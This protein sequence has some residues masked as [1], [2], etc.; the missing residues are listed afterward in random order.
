LSLI[1]S[2]LYRIRTRWKGYLLLAVIG[3]ALGLIAA[4]VVKPAVTAEYQVSGSVPLTDSLHRFGLETTQYAS[5]VVAAKI[6]GGLESLTGASDASIKTESDAV[7]GTTVIT[8]T[9][10]KSLV[11]TG[12]ESRVQT[13]LTQIRSEMAETYAT[14]VDRISQEIT[15]INATLNDLEIS[16]PSAEPDGRTVLLLQRS[17]L[18]QQRGDL[19]A[20]RA[21]A[22][23]LSGTLADAFPIQV[24]R[25]RLESAPLFGAP[26]WALGLS[27]ALLLVILVAATSAIFGQR[28]HTVADVAGAFRD[29]RVIGAPPRS[30]GGSHLDVEET[31]LH[32]D[33]S[34]VSL[35]EIALALAGN[36]AIRSIVAHYPSDSTFR[37]AVALG[38]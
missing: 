28:A 18:V 36:D 31:T 24:L 19:E 13:I 9:G 10:R 35:A 4:R 25:V 23:A 33:L 8:L 16:L 6:L 29:L 7:L 20:T 21:N 37:I 34:K 15:S 14:L 11:D 30:S 3:A 32:V 26:A 22:T 27:V 38:A 1:L 12:V 17:D 2:V 5:P